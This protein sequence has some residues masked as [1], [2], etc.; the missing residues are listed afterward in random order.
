[1]GRARKECCIDGLGGARS[2][3]RGGIRSLKGLGIPC[4]SSPDAERETCS[5]AGIMNNG[6]R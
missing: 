6:V 4:R 1:M 5:Y 2:R 3:S